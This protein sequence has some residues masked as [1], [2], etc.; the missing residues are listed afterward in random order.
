[1]KSKKKLLRKK[2]RFTRKK[3]NPKW[4]MLKHKLIEVIIQL[5]KAEC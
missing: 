2:K 3:I 4:L 5:L 1:M